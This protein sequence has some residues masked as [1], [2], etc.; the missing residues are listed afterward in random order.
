MAVPIKKDINELSE[1]LDADM[2]IDKYGLDNE[3]AEQTSI[4][5]KWAR[6]SAEASRERDYRQKELDETSA[7]LDN[8][9]RTDPE[10][11]GIKDL[12]EAAVKAVIMGDEA[13]MKLKS[14][15]IE[16]TTYAKFMN[17]A[18]AAC[19]QKKTM[20]RMLGDLWLG[21]Y[22]SNVEIRKGEVED[23]LRE[24]MKGRTKRGR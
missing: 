11:Y 15:L 9:I 24:K 16:A 20:L 4:Y 18:V 2:R 21:E 23:R 19:D 7:M 5:S 10:K 6:M 8:E 1:Q 3:C 12:K 17:S 13:V 22:Y 14:D